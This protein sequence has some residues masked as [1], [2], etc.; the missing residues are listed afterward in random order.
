MLI[1][2]VAGINSSVRW[3]LPLSDLTISWVPDPL[4][5]SADPSGLNLSLIEV[6]TTVPFGKE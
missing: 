5:V 6:D 4:A 1:L 3:G 2:E